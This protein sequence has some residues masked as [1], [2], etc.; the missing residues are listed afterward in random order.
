MSVNDPLQK[1]SDVP[2]CVDDVAREEYDFYDFGCSAG[3]SIK[4]AQS[5]FGGV[6]ALGLD[7]DPKKVER[8]QNMGFEA[9][10]ADC[11]CLE[12]MRRVR[13][14]TMMHFLEH[15]PSRKHAR[16]CIKSALQISN[17]FVYIRQPWFDSDGY[18]LTKGLKLYWSDWE[19][20]TLHMTSL[21]LRNILT[22]LRRCSTTG[23]RLRYVIAAL[24][25][26]VS[27]ADPSM[28]PLDAAFD[29]HAYN[30]EAHGPK[31]IVPLDLQA[32]VHKEIVCVAT[33]SP[34]FDCFKLLVSVHGKQKYLVLCQ[35]A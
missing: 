9:R 17:D 16:D 27:S 26:I 35:S 8:T 14:V 22:S 30:E 15:L 3:G 29:S 28:L 23:R 13:F 24:H 34:D 11:T 25:P 32:C 2:K 33:M 18:L 1:D 20:H 21:E 10:V 31:D 19:G 5:K 6:R 4:F 12:G 7:I